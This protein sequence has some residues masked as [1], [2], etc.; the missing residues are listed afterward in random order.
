MK[1][2]HRWSW[3]RQVSLGRSYIIFRNV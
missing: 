1:Q 3:R 2:I